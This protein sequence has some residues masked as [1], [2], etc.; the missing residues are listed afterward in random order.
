MLVERGFAVFAINPKQ[1]ARFRERY[2][3]AGAKDDR[4]D[5]RVLADSLRT[6]RPSFRAVRL[7]APELLLLRELS[8]AE[9]SL[10]QEFRRTANRLRD[11]LH[12]FFPQMLQLCP[13]ADEVWCGTCSSWHRPQPI[14]S[15]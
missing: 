12:R 6:D 1:L 13:A 7:S 3:V 14:P 15:C 10:L 4:R 11:H 2:S 5:A 8:R 9:E